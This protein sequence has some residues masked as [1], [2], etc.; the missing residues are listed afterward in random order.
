MTAYP[1][2]YHRACNELVQFGASRPERAA[3]ARQLIAQ[4]LRDLR[5]KFGREFAQRSRYGLLFISG[6]FPDKGAHRG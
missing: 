4:A 3:F 1:K 5:R 6:H 2:S